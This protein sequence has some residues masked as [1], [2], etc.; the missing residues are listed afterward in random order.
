M[1][2]FAYHLVR[3]VLFALFLAFL[4]F[5]LYSEHGMTSL[6]GVVSYVTRYL[7]VLLVPVTIAMAVLLLLRYVAK[8]KDEKLGFEDFFAGVF[9]LIL[10]VAVLVLWRAQGHDIAG[11]LVTNIPDVPELTRHAGTVG[12]LGV[13]ALEFVVLVLYIIAAPDKRKKP[14]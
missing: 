13:A 3:L 6:E 2:K 14:E 12:T 4:S 9:A 8:S 5:Y 7:P 10:Q 1:I 11:G